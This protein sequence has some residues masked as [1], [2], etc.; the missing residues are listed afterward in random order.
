MISERIYDLIYFIL[1]FTNVILFFYFLLFHKKTQQGINTCLC[2]QIHEI[3]AIILEL[4]TDI[5][6]WYCGDIFL[7]H[8]ESH[9][10]NRLF[11]FGKYFKRGYFKVYSNFLWLFKV[12]LKM[13][14]IIKV[15][16]FV[17]SLNAH[18]IYIIDST[19]T[20]LLVFVMLD[21]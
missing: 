13:Q 6:M 9:C 20:T 10:Q 21:L 2:R 18:K 11:S 5:I 19:L 4:Y 17:L 3:L 7:L 8:F 12:S 1:N 16:C 14:I 15:F